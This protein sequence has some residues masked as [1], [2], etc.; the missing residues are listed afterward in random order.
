MDI[1]KKDFFFN[2]LKYFKDFRQLLQ[3]FSEIKSKN[4]NTYIKINLKVL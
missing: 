3:N 2:Y 1:D 4:L